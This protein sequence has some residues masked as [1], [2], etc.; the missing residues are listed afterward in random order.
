VVEVA[1]RFKL[2]AEQEKKLADLQTEFRRQINN[3]PDEEQRRTALLNQLVQDVAAL[4]EPVQR[5]EFQKEIDKLRPDEPAK[6]AATQPAT[7]QPATTPPARTQPA[8]P[9]P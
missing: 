1:R 7:T 6:P 9:T 4:L 3:I 5:A 8:K 2:T